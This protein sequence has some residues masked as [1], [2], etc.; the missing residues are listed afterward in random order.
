MNN[1]QTLPSSTPAE[2]LEISPEALEVAN[3]YLQSQSI[4]KVAEDLSISTDLVAQILDRREV[5]AYIDNVFSDLGF[6]NRFKMRRAM[7]ALLAKKFQ[8]MDEAGIGSSK[9]ISELMALSH[10][11]SMEHINAQIALEKVRAERGVK[12]QVNV[13]INENGSNYGSLIERLIANN[14]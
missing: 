8:E 6:N 14:V 13:Q 10:K 5:K 1:L 11:M 12:S 2:V 7:D 9:D 3:C 4:G